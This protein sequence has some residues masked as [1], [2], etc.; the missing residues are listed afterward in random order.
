M[1]FEECAISTIQNPTVLAFHLIFII[2]KESRTVNI[3]QSTL[4]NQI[5]SE[6]IISYLKS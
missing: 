2:T 5:L 3:K 1:L 6:K 4:N